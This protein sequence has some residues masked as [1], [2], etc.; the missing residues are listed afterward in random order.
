MAEIDMM[1]STEEVVLPVG[2]DGFAMTLHWLTALLVVTLF[3]LAEIWGFVPRGTP[4][5]H[6]MQSLH[7]S[8]GVTLAV[9]FLL[10]VIWRNTGARR[11]VPLEIGLQHVAALVMHYGLYGLLA[12][13]IVLGFLYRWGQ[14]PIGVFGLFAIPSPLVI[15]KATRHL[16]GSLHNYVGW[17]III[18]AGGHAAVALAHHYLLRDQVLR[19]MLPRFG[20]R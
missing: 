15:D 19:R 14:G 17:L 8:L 12:V 3:A 2:Y 11:V 16:V 20:T 13:Q 7:I 6:G 18:L 1:S 5:R 9:V 4:L 10:R